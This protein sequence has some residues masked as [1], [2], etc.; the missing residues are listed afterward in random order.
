MTSPFSSL[1]SDDSPATGNTVEGLNHRPNVRCSPVS[2]TSNMVA[3][4]K[5]Y[6][7]QLRGRE[8]SMVT[9]QCPEKQMC[10]TLH[11]ITQKQA[12]NFMFSFK[13]S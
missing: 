10:Q 9:L 5:Y 4:A 11:H 1:L 2:S 13:F 7:T 12:S 3:K 6:V 8:T